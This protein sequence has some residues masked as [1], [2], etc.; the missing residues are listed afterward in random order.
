MLAKFQVFILLIMIC[1]HTWAT[2]LFTAYQTALKNDPQLHASGALVKAGLFR[3]KQ[4]SSSFFPNINFIGNYSENSVD[5]LTPPDYD[6]YVYS[7]NLSQAIYRQH[8]IAEYRMAKNQLA[9]VE[10]QHEFAKQNLMVR[11]AGQYFNLLAAFDSLEFAEAETTAVKRQLDQVKK[12][13]DVG[14]IAITDVQESKARYDLTVA[15][16][17]EAENNVS[18]QKETLR[19]ITGEYYSTLKGLNNKMA[20]EIPAPDNMDHWVD[21]A[22]KNSPL[23]GAA[24]AKL[25]QAKAAVELAR[26]GH[27]PNLDL[28]ARYQESDNPASFLSGKRTQTS[29]SLELTAP[30]F[31]SGLTHY[32]VQE[33]QQLFHRAQFEHERTRREIH[34]QTRAAFLNVKAAVA[35]ASALNQALISSKTALSATKAGFNVGTRTSVDILNSQQEFFRAKRDY[36]KSRYDYIINKLVLKLQ[37]GVLEA[38][39]LETIN[40]WLT[41][42]SHKN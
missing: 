16:K 40:Q 30:L 10:D 12:R 34:K 2:D 41:E 33:A 37:I 6:S 28:K 24:Q 9:E 3:K 22:I 25:S 21:Q 29:I 27:V 39:D 42:T 11:L 26:A 35:R 1:S 20:L 15:Q 14:L 13:F 7:I 5:G 19:E 36:A 23:L 4:Q 32:K 8:L 18:L 31:Q 17:I 38:K